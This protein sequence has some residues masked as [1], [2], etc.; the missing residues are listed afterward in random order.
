MKKLKAILLI[1]TLSFSTMLYGCGSNNE[2]SNTV[3]PIEDTSERVDYKTQYPLKLDVYGPDGT[4]YTQ[5]ISKAPTKVIT[6][7]PSATDLLLE[8]GLQDTIVGI[9]K[10]D[11]APDEKWKTAYGSLKV[12]ADK[13]TV[14]K[15]VI[16]GTEPDLVIGRAMPFIDTT[17]GTIPF[18]NEMG[19]PVYTQFASNFIIDQSLDNIILDVKNVGKIFDVQEKANA[20]ADVLQNKLDGITNKV[21]SLPKQEKIKV[22][23]MVTYKDGTFNTFGANST[24]QESML[25]LIN[26]KNV[27][28]KGTASLTSENLI[29]L[30]PDVIVYITA[31]S[32]T[33]TD[34]IAVNK[35]LNDPIIQSVGAIANKKIITIGYDE[36]MDYGTRL[37]DTLEELYEYIY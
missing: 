5:T 6:N 19:I 8:L 15:E 37:F 27:L 32:N 3:I 26:A 21:S 33:T 29:S 13:K 14:S 23:Y 2:S 4:K 35:L 22:L 9:L 16:V 25:S 31:D 34:S 28:E 17:M 24:L 11:N 1:M 12:I 18:L 20:Y 36:I 10:P 7:M 30:N